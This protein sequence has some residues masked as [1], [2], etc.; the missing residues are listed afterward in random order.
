MVDVPVALSILELSFS[1]VSAVV[2]YLLWGYRDRP[3]GI[4][5]LVMVLAASI[6]SLVNGLGTLIASEMITAL[7]EH[8]RW[9]LGA[10]VA[11]GAFYT[12]VEYTNYSRLQ[13]PLV[14]G[15]VV[16]FL[17]ADVLVFVTNP[18]HELALVEPTVDTERDVLVYGAGPLL[19]GHLLISFLIASIGFGLLVREFFRRTLYR[20]QTVILL[21]GIGV[22]IGFFGVESAVSVHPAFNLA[23]LGLTAGSTILLWGIVRGEFLQSVPVAR[24][25]LMKS[26]DDYVI[27]IDTNNLVIDLNEA[28]VALTTDSANYVGEP[29]DT[30]F[31]SYPELVDAITGETDTVVESTDRTVGTVRLAPDGEQRH[32]DLNLSPIEH[33]TASRDPQNGGNRLG[34]LIVLRD[35][36]ET[37]RRE[38]ELDLVK[39]VFARVLRHN[40]RN[41]LNII[42]GNAR[43]LAEQTSGDQADIA[44]VIVDQSEDMIDLSEKARYLEQ[45]I[46][47]PAS[48]VELQLV[49][50]L[51]AAIAEIRDEYP[52]ATV[53]MTVPE[54]IT[55]SVHGGIQVAI[56]NLLENACEHHPTTAPVIEITA[57]E[58]AESVTLCIEDN[59][60]GIPQH[61]IEVIE[62]GV[63]TK[64]EHGSGLGLWLVSWVVDR[65]DGSIAMESTGSGT[66]V[67]LQLR[68]ADEA[69]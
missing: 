9:P 34:T 66:R 15:L 18:L 20:R 56:E 7:F 40:L 26:M 8:L 27:A 2:G 52:D 4:P 32:Y 57:T 42:S 61:E 36:T 46:E 28:A 51:Q 31:G 19:I 22:G 39:Q 14:L 16:C 47:S 50:I 43:L 41:D 33:R 3:A 37:R 45:L 21:A 6:Y 13:T 24:E 44:E 5:V 10:F 62:K 67:E 59:G 53:K 64:L 65:S 11:A 58:D 35:V 49:G 25:T 55:V 48:K 30:V 38:Q 12:G 68:S 17:V 1:V 60:P 63:E 29:I 23:T 69:G 54:I